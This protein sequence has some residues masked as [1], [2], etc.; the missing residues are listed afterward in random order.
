MKTSQVSGSKFRPLNAIAVVG[1]LLASLWVYAGTVANEFV[2]DTVFYLQVHEQRIAQLNLENFIW[3]LT[4]AEAFYWHPVTWWSWAADY[5]LYGGLDAG[6]FHLTNVVI[7]GLNSGL[8]FLLLLKVLG[9][10]RNRLPV[11]ETI[12]GQHA[13]LPAFIAALVF[14]VHPQHVESVAW[15]AE[16]KDLLCQFFLLLALITYFD[17]HSQNRKARWSGSGL[18]LVFF[19]LALMSKPMAVT[20]PLLL[21]L[22]DVYPLGRSRYY[23]PGTESAGPTPVTRLLWEKWPYILAALLV[24]VATIAASQGAITQ[25]PVGIKLLNAFNSIV[26]YI[27]KFLIPVSFTPH[28][29]YFTTPAKGVELQ[30]FI[31]VIGFLAISASVVV[32][33]IKGHRGWLIGWLFYLVSLLPVL[34]LISAGT[35]GMAD[36]FSYF[37]TLPF[38]LAIAIGVKK[39]GDRF[40]ASFQRMALI[41]GL[42]VVLLLGFKTANQVKVWRN[43]LTLFQSIIDIYPDN[44]TARDNMGILLLRAGA[45][46]AAIRQFNAIEQM[47]V[48]QTPMLSW[49]VIAHLETG[50]LDGALRDLVQLKNYA[51]GHPR[52]RLDLDCYHY[53]LGWIHAQLGSPDRAVEQFLLLGP[54]SSLAYQASQ[55][56][57]SIAAGEA[58]AAAVERA[59]ALPG[60]CPALFPQNWR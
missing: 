5:K 24:A 33:W 44:Y 29:P 41:A 19:L 31:P 56:L 35:Q 58:E 59:P 8:L 20:F 1:L 47:P 21:L 38:Y 52:L 13:I 55:W 46:D 36:R 17:Q 51:E 50:N 3:M 53:D 48:D 7:H 57:D 54:D 30:H 16:R 10:T 42:G 34:G 45:Y 12:T 22:L 32:A 14:A 49:R 23:Q 43:E 39:I 60:Y 28:Y 27:S 40:S 26:A 37:P 11:A 9:F 25:V 18:T 2:W 6:G 4:S 15:V